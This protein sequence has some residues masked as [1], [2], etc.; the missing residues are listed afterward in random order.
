M[1]EFQTDIKWFAFN[2][3]TSA[4]RNAQVASAAS[5]LVKHFAEEIK[6]IRGC[7]ECY[8][9]AYE[10]GESSFATPCNRP[11]LLVWANAMDYGF[12]PAKVI[13]VN[14]NVIHV[15][16]FG[17][18][19][20]DNLEPG[21]CYLFSKKRAADSIG[22]GLELDLALKVRIFFL[23][24]SYFYFH[25]MKYQLSIFFPIF[26]SSLSRKSK[27]MLDKFAQNLVISTMLLMAL[28]LNR[29]KWLIM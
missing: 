24:F 6:S 19:T 27:L 29:Q 8:T 14:D 2:C 4:R 25:H 7:E 1:S 17:D 5:Q 21:N 9:N 16:Y 15:R 12:W 11:H 3:G 28:F 23:F 26:P 20:T 22:F 10:Q 18:H 13:T